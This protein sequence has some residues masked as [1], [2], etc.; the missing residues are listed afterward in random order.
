MSKTLHVVPITSYR[1]LIDIV[2]VFL[3]SLETPPRVAILYKVS[4]LLLV[5]ARRY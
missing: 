5:V 2:V 4:F 1:I 3:R